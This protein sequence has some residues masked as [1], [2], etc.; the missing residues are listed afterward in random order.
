[1]FCDYIGRFITR[2]AKFSNML[3]PL[4]DIT[5]FQRALEN[6]YLII[7]SNQRLAAKI[8]EGWAM[9]CC[10]NQLVWNTPRVHSV[11]NWLQLCWELLQ[12]QNDETVAGKSIIGLHE[13]R[14]YWE[15][16]IKTHNPELSYKYAKIASDTNKLL[17]QW[18]QTLDNINE[19]TPA[20]R[21]LQRWTRDHSESLS[22][23]NHITPTQSWRKIKNAFDKGSLDQESE[24]VIYG[25]QSIPPLI[26][27]ILEAA[28]EKQISTIKNKS[29]TKDVC[30]VELRD[31]DFELQAAMHWAAQ[32]IGKNPKTRIGIVI[33]ELNSSVDKI[34]RMM[35]E[36][37][38]NK[39]LESLVN[40]SAGVPLSDT[41]LVSSAFG[42]IDCLGKKSKRRSLSHCLELLYSPY[43]LFNTLSVQDQVD[44]ELALRKT[45]QFDF[46]LSE[47]CYAIDSS[48]SLS[49]AKESLKT[50]VQLNTQKQE[51]YSRQQSFSK[52]AEYFSDALHDLGW[53]GKR[54]LNSIEFQQKEHWRRLL[55]EF[56]R[57]DNLNIEVGIVSALRYLRQFAQDSIFH[58]KTADAPIQLLGLLESSG[59]QFDKLWMTGMSSRTFPKQASISPMLPANFQRANRMPHSLPERELEIATKL[60]ADVKSN[61]QHLVISYPLYNGEEKIQ[62]SP[63]IRDIVKVELESIIKETAIKS[64]YLKQDDFTELFL[65]RAPSFNPKKETISTGAALFKNQSNC[66][67]NS[68]AI[69][70]LKA[71]PLEEPKLGLNALDRGSLLHEIMQCLWRHWRDSTTL[72][73]KPDEELKVQLAIAVTDALDTWAR[74]EVVLRGQEFR[75]IEQGRLE[76]LI[77]E[78]IEY[79]KRRP[80]F[81]VDSLEIKQTVRFG[82]LEVSIRLDRIDK[83]D[84]K[85]L[86]IDYKSGL[87]TASDW[88]GDRPKDPQLPV[89]VSA[90][91]PTVNGCA[92]AQL[93]GGNIKFS[94]VSDSQLIE[95]EKPNDNWI[96]SVEKWRNSIEGLASE[97]SDG[98]SSMEVHHS[99]GILFQTHL[100]PLNRWSE[101]P[102]ITSILKSGK[103]FDEIDS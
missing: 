61:T 46:N 25:F 100:L 75:R 36:A 76:K 9:H 23:N 63:L 53:P 39:G 68:F 58:P 5:L 22:R 37:L 80:S 1:M 3:P 95:N 96:N 2:V 20:L 72:H 34:A 27:E 28:A 73:K 19:D 6:N 98:F 10:T 66:P 41:A 65:D 87:V 74:R 33:P 43:S 56:T 29:F 78:W 85:T 7:T 51:K 84:N 4:I 52:W 54:S 8:I 69:H 57:L 21:Y 24:L 81:S 47:F 82:G 94:G 97:F 32:E 45:K 14:Y 11:E 35:N 67:F 12:D 55:I 60:L 86:I 91:T 49:S 44:I 83:I 42:L 77:W 93:R 71:I 13:D 31:S 79:E 40:I 18:N 102:L 15:R 26:L 92:F 59:L 17:D 89:Y 30:S 103:S 38:S 64:L 88:D 70:R 99:N 90:L 50:F 16:S 62:P 48:N 101:E